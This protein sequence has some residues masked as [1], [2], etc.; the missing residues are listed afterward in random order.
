MTFLG[1]KPHIR[2]INPSQYG[3]RS[4]HLVIIR[5]DRTIQKPLQRLEKRPFIYRPRRFWIL[6]SSRRMT[7][8]TGLLN[9][10]NSLIAKGCAWFNRWAYP[11]CI[12]SL[13]NHAVIG[14]FFLS[15]LPLSDYNI[16]IN[17]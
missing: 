14:T 10:F 12:P 8:F 5:L 2:P 1:K 15:I 11:A 13:H 7:K 17:K 16:L 3:K 4:Q 6:R 9:L